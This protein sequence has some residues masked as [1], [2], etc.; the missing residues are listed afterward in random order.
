MYKTR[1]CPTTPA[2]RYLPSMKYSMATAWWLS[3]SWLTSWVSGPVTSPV[4][5]DGSGLSYAGLRNTSS[6]QDYFLGIP[7]A[8]PPVGPLRF[9]PPVPWTSNDTNTVDATRA[10][11][12]CEQAVAG[13]TTNTVSEDCLT[14]NIC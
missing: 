10:G 5:Y 7:F 14:L 13:A 8:Q 3:T 4:I 9:K 6:N 1:Q 11:H 2:P 12:S